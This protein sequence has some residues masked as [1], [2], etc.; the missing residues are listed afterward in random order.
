MSRPRAATSVA[1]RMGDLLEVE[2]A[3]KRSMLRMRDF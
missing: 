2:G 1:M 3:V